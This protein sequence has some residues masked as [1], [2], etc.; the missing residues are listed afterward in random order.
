MLTP[1]DE[2]LV[3]F[4]SLEDGVGGILCYI[5][6]MIGNLFS[7]LTPS[8]QFSPATHFHLVKFVIVSKRMGLIN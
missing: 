8:Y 1:Y 2:G 4:C 6:R 3:L 7:L 5:M